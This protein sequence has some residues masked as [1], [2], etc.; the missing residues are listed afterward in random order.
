MSDPV[1]ICG[2]EKCCRRV[3]LAPP[4]ACR[5]YILV[6][7]ITDPDIVT[8]ILEEITP[9][10]IQAAAFFAYKNADFI[11]REIRFRYMRYP[12]V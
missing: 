3:V 6:I 5:L 8:T 12:L 9:G 7:E 10:Y 1:L 2:I 11:I 4:V